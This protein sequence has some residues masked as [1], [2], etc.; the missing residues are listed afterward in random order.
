M[1]PHAQNEGVTGAGPVLKARI[2]LVDDDKSNRDSLGMVLQFSGFDVVTAADVSEALAQIGAQAF[3]V[4]LT[5]LHMPDPGDGL[6]VASAMRHSH[7]KAATFIYSGYPEMS[8]S[9]GC[10]SSSNRSGLIETDGARSPC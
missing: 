1:M 3:D 7:P 10:N 4:L 2:L 8:C 5:D 6:T 9:N